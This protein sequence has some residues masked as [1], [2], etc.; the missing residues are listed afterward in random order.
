[1][2][3]TYLVASAALATLLVV[4]QNERRA[5]VG[6]WTAAGALGV[7]GVRTVAAYPP[8]W[9]DKPMVLNLALTALLCTGLLFASYGADHQTRP[10]ALIAGVAFVCLTARMIALL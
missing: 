5:S 8:E 6:G 10:G 3:E 7:V 2:L 4:F 9:W 1:M